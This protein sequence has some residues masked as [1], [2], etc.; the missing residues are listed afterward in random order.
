MP[1]SV[2]GADIELSGVNIR[3]IDDSI[4][5]GDQFEVNI[6][7]ENPDTTV[8]NVD[9]DIEIYYEDI[10]VHDDT[11]R[12]DV[13]EDNDTWFTVS[14]STFDVKNDNIWKEMLLGYDCGGHDIRVV[15]G[16]DVSEEEDEDQLTIDGY[17]FDTFTV[18][19]ESPGENDEITVYVE[20][21]TGEPDKVN[22]V[23]TQF[24]SN[25]EWD[26][27]D[28][29]DEDDTNND[30]EYKFTIEDISSFK[31]D[32]NGIYQVDVYTSGYC[33]E[34]KT[35]EVSRT[36][37][38]EGPFPSNPKVGEQF[39]VRV[40]DQNGNPLRHALVVANVNK[41]KI[42]ST[43]DTDGYARFTVNQAG[44]FSFAVS[45]E[46]FDDAIMTFTVSDLPAMQVSISPASPNTGSPASITV[47]SGG[48]P[49]AS[50]TLKFIL[51]DGTEKSQ[52]TGS[53][54]VTSYTPD[55]AGTYEVVAEKSGYNEARTTF[56]VVK[57][58]LDFKVKISPEE[59]EV[60]DEV[61]VEVRG[62]DNTLLS[63]ASVSVSGPL[64]VSGT[65]D[66]NG[67]Y[68]FKASKKGKYTVSVSKS[69]YNP[70][71][72]NFSPLGFM[73][74][75]LTPSEVAVGENI[76]ATV[77]DL[78]SGNEV[79]S[80]I[81]IMDDL[82]ESVYKASGPKISFVPE[83]KGSYKIKASASEYK[84]TEAL[85]LVTPKIA[86]ITAEFE[87]TILH[88]RTF[89]D[90]DPLGNLSLVVITPEDREINVTTDEEGKYDFEVSIEGVY[91]IKVKDEVYGG[92]GVQ[93]EYAESN[94]WWLIL[95]V[96]FLLVLI[97]V[98]ISVIIVIGA[99]RKNRVK[100]FKPLGLPKI[101]KPKE[102][103]SRGLGS[104]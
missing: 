89:Y 80:S 69:D 100:G 10:L 2:S 84:D 30:G 17:D 22:V 12:V 5:V 103:K 6:T 24:G 59:P 13:E 97:I 34:T 21:K 79:S 8:S 42:K 81:E 55:Q 43:T 60:G 7:L 58:L 74:L 61:T 70:S 104:V 91:Q 39:Q 9:V 73:E 4:D 16:G 85:F 77:L 20:D 68:S 67:R 62:S 95:F 40:Q 54:G 98:G 92:E 31:D 28:E 64:S 3:L 15:V 90:D 46:E 87:G 53:N 35:F 50:A 83:K 26:F 88:I 23:V 102:K 49:V 101:T 71:S 37:S 99:K 47:T 18:K 82:D 36:M 72:T 45:I 52:L 66:A 96:L 32:P 41:E 33:K 63:G 56:S 76:T 51:P 75:I 94:Y 57:T 86:E 48:K 19:P 29:R 11:V 27:D 14:S 1:Q 38:I 44:T 93:E 65:S 78:E 25:D